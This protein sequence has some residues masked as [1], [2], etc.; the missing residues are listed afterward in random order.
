[1][2]KQVVQALAEGIP[3]PHGT[4]TARV[5]PGRFPEEE[6]LTVYLAASGDTIHVLDAIVYHGWKWYAPWIELTR[7]AP[8]VN[9]GGRRIAYYD[10]PLESRLLTLFAD[11]LKPPGHLFVSYETDRETARA[12]NDGVPAPATRLGFK[13]YRRGFTWY[14]DW[15]YPEGWREGGQKL[16]AEKPL[17]EEHR[18]RHHQVIRRD[19]ETFLAAEP[20]D[21]DTVA[22][23]RCRARQVLDMP[24]E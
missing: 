20:D 7:I 8:H 9:R 19:L 10:S 5:A 16:Q 2:P 12:L 13:L 3:T 1:M 23:A 21:S 17:D 14:K 22:A 18:R 11:A 4:L 15:Y 24:S 6:H